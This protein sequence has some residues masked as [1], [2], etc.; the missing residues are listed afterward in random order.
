MVSLSS[1]TSRLVLCTSTIGV[2]PVTV[3]VSATPPTFMSPSILMTP[4][5]DSNTSSRL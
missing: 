5:P 1:V 2:S 3:T 4:L